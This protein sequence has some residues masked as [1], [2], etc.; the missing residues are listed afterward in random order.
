M[1]QIQGCSATSP[2][3]L[4]FGHVST[5]TPVSPADYLAMTFERDAEFVNGEVVERSMPDLVHSRIHYLLIIMLAELSRR[6][7][8][9]TYPELRVQVAPNIYRIPDVAVFS[10]KPEVLVP[11]TPPLL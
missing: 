8:V 10:A 4:S 1:E 7:L 9:F 3:V 2:P 5:K 11:E 6:R